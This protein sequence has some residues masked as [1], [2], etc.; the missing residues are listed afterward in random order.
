MR[1]LLLSLALLLLS[2]IAA[3]ENPNYDPDFDNNGCYTVM[4]ILSFLVILMPDDA[5]MEAANPDYDPDFDNNGELTITDLTGLLTWFGGCELGLQCVSPTM[6]GYTYD[7]VEIGDQCWFAENLRTTE[8]ADGSPIPEASSQSSW[9]SMAIEEGVQTIYGAFGPCNG[10][11]SDFD[12]CAGSETLAAFGRLYSMYAVQDERGLCPVGWHVPTGLDW[13]QLR[14]EVDDLADLM[15]VGVWPGS[16]TDATGFSAVPAGG[17]ATSGFNNAG[18]IGFWWCS[19]NYTDAN[20]SDNPGLTWF[21]LAVG[22]VIGMPISPVA[23][24]NSIRCIQS[25]D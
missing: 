11:Y 5:G 15:A 24:G 19:D 9:Q 20:V 16:T 17:C 25:E 18:T 12:P 22:T 2:G 3:Q 10:V 4:D 1:C 13:V 23:L 8:Y 6:N 14:D 21:Q 7:V